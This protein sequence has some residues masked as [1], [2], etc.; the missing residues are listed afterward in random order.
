[1]PLR[2]VLFPSPLLPRGLPKGMH[3]VANEVK[4]QELWTK[5]GILE[6]DTSAAKNSLKKKL[7]VAFPYPYSNGLSHFGTHLQFNQSWFTCASRTSPQQAH[8]TDKPMKS[9][10]LAKTRTDIVWQWNI[11]AKMNFSQDEIAKFQDPH[12]WLTPM[13]CYPQHLLQEIK[14]SSC[15]TMLQKAYPDKD[16]RPNL[17]PSTFCTMTSEDL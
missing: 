14:Y 4:I 9:K 6:L 12:Y 8:P 15:S 3:S 2:Q 1:M 5:R 13:K 7:L 10:V 11:L 16:T 17:A